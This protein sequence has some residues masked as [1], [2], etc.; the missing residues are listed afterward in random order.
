M[1]A[2][3]NCY[4]IL[5]RCQNEIK[6]TLHVVVE[7]GVDIPHVA[8]EVQESVRRNVEKMTG[9]SLSEVDVN[10]QGVTV[11]AKNGGEK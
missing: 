5:T 3:A 10:I 9:L 2:G 11:P 7:Y 1:R 4:R 8:A 6:I